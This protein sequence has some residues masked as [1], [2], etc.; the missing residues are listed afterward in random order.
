M[1]DLMVGICEGFLLSFSFFLGGGEA[2]T[3]DPEQSWKKKNVRTIFYVIF[4]L[5]GGNVE[6]SIPIHLLKRWPVLKQKT[7]QYTYDDQ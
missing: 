1:Q 3:R 2:K 6:P 5:I 4:W 7:L